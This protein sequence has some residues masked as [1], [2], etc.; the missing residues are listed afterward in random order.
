MPLLSGLLSTGLPLAVLLAVTGTILLAVGTHVQ[1]REV[2]RLVPHG[3]T[4]GPRLLLTAPLWLLGGALIGLETVANVAALG[5]APVA[6]I[7][8]VGTLSLVVAVLL[9]AMTTRTPPSG[10]VLGA[11]LLV[12]SSVTVFVTVAA[13]H[14]DPAP[15]PGPG[16]VLLALGLPA[17]AGAGMVVARSG[18]GHMARVVAAGVLFGCVASGAHVVASRLLTG[19]GLDPAAWTVLAGLAPASAA[20]VWLVQTAYASGSA[21]SVLAGLTVIDPLTAIAVGGLVLG[22][23]RPVP[24]GS[25]VLLLVSAACALRGVHVLV[26]RGT[27]TRAPASSPVPQAADSTMEGARGEGVPAPS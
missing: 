3:G 24:L 26:H 23:A 25:A 11:V 10:A 2:L 27:G 22:E 1:Q 12:V 17:L 4:P 14:M 15:A 21:A 16:V 20:G 7:Q 8:P 13:Q 9:T 5:M 19:D 18:T 6:I